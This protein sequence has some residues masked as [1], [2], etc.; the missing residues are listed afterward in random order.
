M[1]KFRIEGGHPISGTFEPRG[2]KNAVLPML[3]ASLL[4]DQPVTLENIPLI[5]DVEVMLELLQALGVQIT[6]EGHTLTLQASHL[7]TTELDPPLCARVRTSILL[8]GP[9]AARHGHATIYPPGGDIIGRRR[10][11]THFHGLTALGI[12]I[13]LNHAYHFHAHQLTSA[14]IILDEAS[15]TATENI[16]MAATLATGQTT[17]YNAACEPHVQDLAHLLNA[18]GARIT[19]IGTNRLHIE[20]VKTLHGTTHRVQPDYIEVGSFI[21][22]SVATGGHLTIPRAGDPHILRIL[23][24]TYARLGV[25]WHLT[26]D[27]LHLPQQTDRSIEGDIGNATPKIEDGIWPAFPSDLMSVAIVLATQTQGT[28]LFFEKMFESR[29]YFVDHLMSMGA[30]I[31]PCDPHR[32]VVVGPTQLRGST[33]TSPDIR[34]GMAMLIAACCANGKSLIKNAGVIDRGYEAIED[35]LTALGAHM[36]R[37]S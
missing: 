22:A 25:H 27:T 20:G 5:K 23:Q 6:L 24:R 13:D 19:G 9:L 32:V 7:S 1:A 36:V 35:R 10:L 8:A 2:N 11:D 31:I 21:A 3:A 12:Q 17:L 30:N 16:L 18:M 28:A 4:T 29:M 34:A 33:L 14:D 37:E 26:D 15:V